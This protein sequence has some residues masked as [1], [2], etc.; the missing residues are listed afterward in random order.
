MTNIDKE[1]LECDVCGPLE[2]ELLEGC[3]V[4]DQCPNCFIPDRD[5][6]GILVLVQR[7]V[8]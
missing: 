1:V 5:C 4:G 7:A 3:D 8:E 2:S 6:D